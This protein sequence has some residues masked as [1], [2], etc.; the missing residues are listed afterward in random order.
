MLSVFRD[1]RS[2]MTTYLLWKILGQDSS[3]LLNDPHIYIYIYIFYFSVST[4][5]GAITTSLHNIFYRK[6]TFSLIE[7]IIICAFSLAMI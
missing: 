5:K 6:K 3:Y 4:T 2:P 1:L 7:S